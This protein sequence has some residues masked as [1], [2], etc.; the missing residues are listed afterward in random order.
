MI[1]VIIWYCRNGPCLSI[2]KEQIPICEVLA[3]FRAEKYS[4]SEIGT[5]LILSVSD[6]Q[7]YFEIDK[8]KYDET[9]VFQ[10]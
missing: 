8:G 5:K 3:S 9:N 4:S 1:K 2:L 7:A 6:N 10:S